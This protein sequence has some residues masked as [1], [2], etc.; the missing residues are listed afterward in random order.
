MGRNDIQIVTAVETENFI[1]RYLA[2][3]MPDFPDRWVHV[4]I[5]IEFKN[6]IKETFLWPSQEDL[7]KIKK[8]FNPS[9]PGI[10]MKRFSF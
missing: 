9:F 7:H 4:K 2:L 1:K 8:K 10:T 3:T 5:F 6:V